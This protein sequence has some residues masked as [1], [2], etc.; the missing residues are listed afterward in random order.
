MPKKREISGTMRFQRS[1]VQIV[2]ID[3]GAFRNPKVAK[4]RHTLEP[5]VAAALPVNTVGF[6]IGDEI[7]LAACVN[8]RRKH[9]RSDHLFN[10]LERNPRVV[11]PPSVRLAVIATVRT[12]DRHLSPFG[13]VDRSVSHA[14]EDT[15]EGEYARQSPTPVES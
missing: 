5:Q 15:S 2:E 9:E 12:D 11:F 1:A 4:T 10:E 6:D 7:K 3:T 8:I 13:V 14:T